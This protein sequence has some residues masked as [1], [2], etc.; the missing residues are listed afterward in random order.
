M[1]RGT[2]VE[3]R[4]RRGDPAQRHPTDPDPLPPQGPRSTFHCRLAPRIP[5]KRHG[6][7]MRISSRNRFL[8]IAV[9][10][11][12]V[13]TAVVAPANAAPTPAPCIAPQAGPGVSAAPFKVWL[14]G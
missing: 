12:A 13:M 10:V 7:S 6:G 9:A 8:G 5:P 3:S 4:P 14:A 2:D 1:G 11:F